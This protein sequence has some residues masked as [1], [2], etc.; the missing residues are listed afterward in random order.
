MIWPRLRSFFVTHRRWI[1]GVPATILVVGALVYGRFA[2]LSREYAARA[3]RALDR[4]DVPEAVAW[5][6]K[7]ASIELPGLG[8]HEEARARLRR[9]RD[10]HAATHPEWSRMAEL[11]LGPSGVARQG[12]AG[13]A[14]PPRPDPL[15]RCFSGVAFAAFV[16]CVFLL[17]FRG[18]TP[19]LALRLPQARLWG[20][21][22]IVFFTAWAFLIRY[23]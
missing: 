20:A 17:I 15:W 1:V 12:A 4:G 6:Q 19:E 2:F 11:A 23:A 8:W 18:F 10:G 5:L 7:A 14:R 16:G 22:S 13:D 3:G 9:I 21:G